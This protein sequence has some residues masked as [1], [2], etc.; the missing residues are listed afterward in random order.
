MREELNHRPEGT[1]TFDNHADRPRC[2][3]LPRGNLPHSHNG[4]SSLQFNPRG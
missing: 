2:D 3:K 4:F 1:P